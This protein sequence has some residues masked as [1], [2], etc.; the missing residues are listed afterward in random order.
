MVQVGFN[1]GHTSSAVKEYSSRPRPLL[2]RFLDLLFRGHEIWEY[3]PSLQLAVWIMERISRNPLGSELP[4]MSGVH[5]G[6]CAGCLTGKW[7]R[8]SN[9]TAQ[10]GR[11]LEWFRA[12]YN[13]FLD[14]RHRTKLLLSCKGPPVVGTAIA[15]GA[16]HKTHFG[17][18]N[19]VVLSED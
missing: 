13:D 17:T 15:L 16:Y 9:R 6:P 2:L 4:A 8:N 12:H 14:E 11:G 19:H 18:V 5:P 3:S 10:H 7:F 1:P